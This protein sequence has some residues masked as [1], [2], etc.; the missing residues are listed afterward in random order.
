MAVH[1]KLIQ[2]QDIAS[3]NIKTTGNSSIWL[4]PLLKYH[5]KQTA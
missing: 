3:H 2:Y 1:E 4:I 5:H